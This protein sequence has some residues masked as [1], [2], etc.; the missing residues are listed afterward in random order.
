MKMYLQISNLYD[1]LVWYEL[2]YSIAPNQG[3]GGNYHGKS[4]LLYR[5]QDKSGNNRSHAMNS[6][7][8]T[9]KPNLQKF[10]LWSTENLKVWVSTRALKS[11][12]VERV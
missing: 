3:K 5:S 10:A 6:T 9:V 7:K 2:N 4:L 12:K 8:R 11:G 1:M